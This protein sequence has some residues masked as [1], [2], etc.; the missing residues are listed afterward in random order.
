MLLDLGLPPQNNYSYQL[1]FNDNTYNN[2]SNM[3]I[4]HNHNSKSTNNLLPHLN[5]PSSAQTLVQ[6]QSEVIH[7]N[8]IA[9]YNKNSY[10]QRFIINNK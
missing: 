2:M 8:N 6:Q 1:N 7:N 3:A 10:Y 4:L 5:Y 9:T